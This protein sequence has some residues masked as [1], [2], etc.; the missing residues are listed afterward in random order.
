MTAHADR[1]IVGPV[2]PG[3]SPCLATWVVSHS[4]SRW[5][6]VRLPRPVR[7]VVGD[8]HGRFGRPLTLESGLRPAVAVGPAG[9]VVVAWSQDGHLRFARRAS[10]KTRFS[11]PASLVAGA[12]RDFVQLA[13]RL[14]A[15]TVVLFEHRS[16][17]ASGQFQT[18][19]ET[20]QLSRNG[21]PGAVKELGSGA[22]ARDDFTAGPGG[23]VAA[24][25]LTAPAPAATTSAVV[26]FA[27]DRGWST[28]GTPVVAP[29]ASAR[30]AFAPRVAIDGSGRSV[31]LYQEKDAP[32]AFSR[33]APLYAVTSTS[34]ARQTLTVAV[35]LNPMV[36][37]YRGGAIAAWQA[38]GHRWGVALERHGRF[39]PA[40]VP[41]GA[42]PSQ[43]GE[44]FLYSRALAT[45][46]PYAALVW[47][48]HD[49]S[50]R[51]SVGVL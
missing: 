9:A 23:Q 4:S 49:G 5:S 6:A 22:I 39:S 12:Q 32:A 19:L 35:V 24:C 37:A 43:M 8:G 51:V 33:S 17:D 36:L 41:R 21:R 14:D 44:D 25:C 16:R 47:T 28:F 50:I 11:A 31:L 3:G 10:G 38:P 40:P 42:G 48:A 29:V 26:A 20:V 15:R 7:V 2:F 1:A 27:P 30:R 18:T 13:A 34:A 45:G 46:G